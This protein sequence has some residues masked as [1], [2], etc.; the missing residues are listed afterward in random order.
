MN[1]NIVINPNLKKKPIPPKS[2]VDTNLVTISHLVHSKVSSFKE[3][4]ESTTKHINL[5][6]IFD[7]LDSNEVTKCM[8]ELLTL[9]KK[10]R[11]IEQIVIDNVN[12]TAIIDK[13]QLI[14][15]DLSSIL[16]SFGTYKLD[17]IVTVCIGDNKMV[18]DA[19]DNDKWSLLQKYFHPISYSY[20][21]VKNECLTKNVK[22]KNNTL[23]DDPNSPVT[24]NNLK[25]YDIASDAKQF[26]LKLKGIRVELN[27]DKCKKIIICGVLDDILIELLSNNF[28]NTKKNEILSNIKSL[29][30]FHPTTFDKFMSSLTLKDYLMNDTYNEF[31]LSYLCIYSSVDDLKQKQT[32]AVVNEFLKNDLYFK[33][34]LIM[35]LLIV[36][37]N[38]EN[39]Y[40]A[41]LLYDLISNDTNGIVDT[42]EQIIIYDSFPFNIKQEFK[43]AMKHT[44]QYTADLS[45]FDINKI[46]LE[47]Q[48]CLMNT[49]NCVKEK[50]MIKYKEV[51]S[52]SEDGGTKARAYLDGLLKIPFNIY[53][54]EPILNKMNDIRKQLSSIKDHK[55]FNHLEVPDHLTNIHILHLLGHMREIIY[56][57]HDNDTII[58]S[59]SK[60]FGAL[61]KSSIVENINSINSFID[62]QD[63]KLDKIILANNK[64]KT[65]PKNVT[66]ITHTIT[67]KTTLMNNLDSWLDNI[68]QS[69]KFD[70][71]KDVLYKHCVTKPFFSAI[72]NDP[73]IS[74]A[75]VFNTLNNDMLAIAKYMEKVKTTLN[76]CVHSHT[77]AKKQIE[78]I[79]GQWLNGDTNSMEACVIGFEGNPGIGKTTLAKGLSKCLLDENGLSRPLSI[80][81]IGGDSNASTL[82]GH[83]Y[84]YVGS[85]WGQIVQ[86]LMDQKCMNPIIVID[87]VDKISKTEHGREIVGV[88]THLLDPSQNK[89]FQDKYF[90]GI[91]LDLSKIL[92]ILSYNDVEAI[93]R[94]MLDRIHRIKFE[95]LS[96]EDKIVISKTHLLPELYAKFGLNNIFN[97]SDEVLKFI[98]KEYTL[99]PGV[100]KL[101]EKLFDIIGEVNLNILSNKC[102]YKLPIEITIEDVQH[103]FFKDNRTVKAQKIHSSSEVGVINALWANEMAQGGVLPLQVSFVPSNKFLELTLTGSLGEVMQESIKVSLTTAWNLTSEA[104]RQEVIHKYNNPAKNEVYGLHIHCPS[105]ST[106][107]DGPSATTAFTVIIYS[108]FNNLKIKNYFGITGE[109]SFDRKLTEIG[110]LR[111]KIIHSIPAGITEFIYPKENQSDFEKIMTTYKDNDLIKGIKFHCIE[112][113]AE[114]LD[115]ILEK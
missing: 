62:A 106:K 12:V 13:L 49:S 74:S 50:A 54:K 101:K 78:R 53:K 25:C 45:N 5:N 81:A 42:Q 2:P 58:R 55:L 112:T 95:S 96:V 30:N 56:N 99:E 115:L 82:V 51:K 113:I 102:E 109:T 39:Q 93:D 3:I 32:A 4:I 88:L 105:I 23:V 111:E 87:E 10:I 52:K 57:S 75:N 61:D 9:N 89:H 98:I 41:Y 46:P 64:T 73:L 44:I 97:F 18:I 26:N 63:I 70:A 24:H 11:D 68:K 80:I 60:A 84:T 66:K 20:T 15:N 69:N 47:Q 22:T 1:N 77:T 67:N 110:G 16:K 91:N 114:V 19:I 108:L 94:I 40:L 7:V 92:F 65:S 104:V 35:N 29:V 37:N 85:T 100:R 83:S 79:I 38:I 36:C 34:N 43:N 86:I 59:F 48:I 103:K 33:R 6:K 72:K 28:I 76:E 17:D 21:T 107:K 14:N 90:S 27:F 31:F 71:L 8:T